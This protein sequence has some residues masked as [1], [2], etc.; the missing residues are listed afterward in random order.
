MIWRDS[1]PQCSSKQFKKNGHFYNGKQNY[2]CKA[3]GCQ[4]VLDAK[5]RLITAEDR[6]LVE[7]LLR[8]RLS[9]RGICRAVGVSLTWLLSFVVDCYEA[10]PDDLNIHLPEQ[11]DQVIVQRL[12]VEA[13]ETWSFV[14]KKTNK[15]W[16]WLALD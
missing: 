12:E 8:E 1:C 4:F 13:D 11:P 7:R 14:A 2:R 16:L 3:C 10:A 9:L 5:N 15:Q 6:A